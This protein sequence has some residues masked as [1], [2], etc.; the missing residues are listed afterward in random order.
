MKYHNDGN[1]SDGIRRCILYC[2]LLGYRFVQ[3]K[4]CIFYIVNAVKSKLESIECILV[5]FRG[6]R[7]YSPLKE[8]FFAQTQPVQTLDVKTKIMSLLKNSRGIEWKIKFFLDMYKIQV[9]NMQ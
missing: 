6:L 9:D 7:Y 8:Y 1:T 3:K 2:K 4:G 5:I